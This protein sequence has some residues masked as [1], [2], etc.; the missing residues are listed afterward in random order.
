[1][2]PAHST[3]PPIN[4]NSQQRIGCSVFCVRLGL[5]HSHLPNLSVR[6]VL[7]FRSGGTLCAR[8]GTSVRG[9]N[10]PKPTSFF[11][12]QDVKKSGSLSFLQTEHP[13]IHPSSTRHVPHAGDSSV[14]AGTGPA[15]QWGCSSQDGHTRTSR[16]CRGTVGYGE[17]VRRAHAH[18]CKTPPSPTPLSSHLSPSRTGVVGPDTPQ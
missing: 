13:H 1:M 8:P 10:T 16:G 12:H 7:G 6:R 5:V 15:A 11:E 17:T 18:N 4:K 9:G 3:Y 14:H 2:A